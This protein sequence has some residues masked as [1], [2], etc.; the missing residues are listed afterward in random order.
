M[1]KARSPQSST[2]ELAVL[3]AEQ[4]K[5]TF[6]GWYRNPTG[7][8]NSIAVPYQEGTK[9]RT[10]YPDFVFV[11]EVDGEIF[12]DI[13]DPHRPDESDTSPK[14]QGLAAYAAEH[15]EAVRRVDAVIKEGNNLRF[16]DLKNPAT[17]KQ[18]RGAAGEDTIRSVF[19]DHGGQY[20]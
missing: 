10:L 15:S 5:E 19:K 9:A 7:G 3:A 12:L 6:V 20:D 4:K 8:P 11:H 14:W 2:T 17:V 13:V 16:I 1:L 18:L